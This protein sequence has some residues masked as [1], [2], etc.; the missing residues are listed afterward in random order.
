MKILIFSILLSCVSLA[1]SVELV[2]GS[3]TYHVLGGHDEYANQII[4]NST[5]WT[6]LIGIGYNRFFDDSCGASLVS[7]KFYVGRNSVAEPIYGFLWGP[8]YR[9]NYF[10]ISMVMG[11]YFQ[12][13]G[14]FGDRGIAPYSLTDGHNAFVMLAGFEV[15]LKL[16]VYKD[17]FIKLDSLFTPTIITEGVSFGVNF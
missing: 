16:P 8:G 12:D 1:D 14:P 7:Y 6:P 2:T 13:N 3:V 15:D 4:G 5:L 11:G 10:D 17:Y 9:G